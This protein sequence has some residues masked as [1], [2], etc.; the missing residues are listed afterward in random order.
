M[1]KVRWGILA[2]GGIAGAFAR[3]LKKSKTGTL[4]AVGSRTQE[5]AD[6]FCA[7]H[8]GKGYATYQGVADDPD[9][10]AV[11]I[12]SPHHLHVA[13]TIMCA[14]AGKHILCEKPF[15]LDAAEAELALAAVKEN[16]VYFCEAFMYRFHPQTQ[17]VLKLV[18]SGAVGK[19]GHIRAE[20]SFQAGRDWQNFRTS[21]VVGGGGTMDV[22]CYCVSYCRAVAGAEPSRVEYS[23]VPA[24]DGYDAWGAG[25]LHF[26]GDIT[27]SIATG[28]HLQMENQVVIYGDEGKIVVE[29]PWF[30]SA[31]VRLYKR[32]EDEPQ[33]LGPW[34]VDDLYANEADGVAADIAQRYSN[35]M[36]PDDT[37]GNMRTL[38]AMR[39]SGGLVFG[40]GA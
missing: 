37:L 34:T 14:K 31:Q 12:A 25:L 7:E 4:V 26:P 33:V 15:T 10:D 29:S 38:D 28:V 20:F 8:G 23:F 3:G 11:Y 30:C 19:V 22:G 16:D 21:R 5:K 32:G 17:E 36:T 6:A 9:V 18:K 13:D 40:G 35:A 1:D 2:T 24:G 39:K 27:A